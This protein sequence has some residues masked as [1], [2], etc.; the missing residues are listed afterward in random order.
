MGP[1]KLLNNLNQ[2]LSFFLI[3]YRL[4]IF[5]NANADPYHIEQLE[6]LFKQSKNPK[7]SDNAGNILK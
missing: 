2:C 3:G 6:I 5:S 1:Q 4:H 7:L